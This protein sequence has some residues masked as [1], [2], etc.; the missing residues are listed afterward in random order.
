MV[1]QNPDGMITGELI[2]RIDKTWEAFW[3]GGISN[4]ITVI[5]QMTY[6]LFIRRLDEI[7]TQREQKARFLGRPIE[8]AIYQTGD[9]DLRWDIFKNKDQEVMFDLFRKEDGVF[10]SMKRVA[11]NGTAF[12]KFMKGA[13][14]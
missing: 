1:Y 6:L 9:Y 5:E 7:P 3:T 10:D 14:S 12:A 13:P 4:P 11:E 8:S 2:S